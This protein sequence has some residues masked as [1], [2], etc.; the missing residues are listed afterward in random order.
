VNPFAVLCGLLSVCML[1]MHGAYFINI[2]TEGNLQHRARITA[3]ITSILSV[4]LFSIG[5]ICIYTIIQGYSLSE[6]ISHFGP[7]NPLLKAVTKG[8][9]TWLSNYR[10]YPFTLIFPLLGIIA[11]LLAMCSIKRAGI[12]FIFSALSIVG[13]IGTV[14][15]SMFPFILPSSLNPNQS[16]LVWDSS[17]SQ[18]TLGI[19]LAATVIFMPIILLYTSWV[20]HVLRG[21]VTAETVINDKV[22]Y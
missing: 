15:I 22:A 14:G 19:M 12:A 18:L 16:L 2:R 7:S 3:R 4:V 13:I 8:Q 11:P 20:Y 5:G 9:G 21:K 1:A 6:S 17:S 10:N